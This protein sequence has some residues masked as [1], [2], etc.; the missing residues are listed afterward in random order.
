M[1]IISRTPTEERVLLPPVTMELDGCTVYIL[2]VI[3]VTD[4]FGNRRYLVSVQA[5]CYGKVSKQA[6]FDVR[7]EAELINVLRKEL[8]LFKSIVLSGAHD[9][10]ARG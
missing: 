2:N 7:S 5:E 1:S 9:V 4:L 8:V 3:P 10:Y 6:C